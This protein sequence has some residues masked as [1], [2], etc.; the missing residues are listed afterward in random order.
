ML[1]VSDSYKH[2][3]KTLSLGIRHTIGNRIRI[4]LGQTHTN[5]AAEMPGASS[6]R[7]KSLTYNSI[8]ESS[9]SMVSR[10]LSQPL[11]IS[12]RNSNG[13]YRD[14]DAERLR[15]EAPRT[16]SVSQEHP[17]RSHSPKAAIPPYGDASMTTRPAS[18]T[19]VRVDRINAA[20]KENMNH[21]LRGDRY[22]PQY[23]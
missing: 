14:S 15:S 5:H 4:K 7:Q 9:T 2:A 6:S 23:Y 17:S 19:S 12:H 3:L 21:T 18:V 8:E 16:A 22:I 10:T 13:S 1:P 11:S 20:R